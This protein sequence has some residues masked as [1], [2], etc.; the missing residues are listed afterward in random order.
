MN[1]PEYMKLGKLQPNL[2]NKEYLE[3]K[4]IQKREVLEK[5]K[6]LTDYSVIVEKKNKESMY[7]SPLKKKVKIETQSKREKVK[8]LSIQ[9]N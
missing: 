1:S 8:L 4:S 9:G 7:N 2:N 6:R 3:R 5:L